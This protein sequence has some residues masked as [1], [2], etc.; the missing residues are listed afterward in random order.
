MIHTICTLKGSKS[1][2]VIGLAHKDLD[3]LRTGWQ[4]F[5]PIDGLPID[6]I[7]MAGTTE[8]EMMRT[9]EKFGGPNG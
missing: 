7:V 6:V 2:L 9:V 1:V 5:I 3:Q 4:G 8:D